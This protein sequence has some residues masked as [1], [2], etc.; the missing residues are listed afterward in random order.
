LHSLLSLIYGR[1]DFKAIPVAPSSEYFIATTYGRYDFKARSV[2]PSSE[3]FPAPIDGRYD[4]QA[5]AQSQ[6]PRWAQANNKT[7][8]LIDL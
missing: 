1:Y 5:E 8:S 7:E 4:Y 3:Y 6:L 2:V